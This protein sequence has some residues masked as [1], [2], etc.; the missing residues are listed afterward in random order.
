[1]P[2]KLIVTAKETTSSDALGCGERAARPEAS[3]CLRASSVLAIEDRVDEPKCDV[4]HVG[5]LSPTV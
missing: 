3:Q 2:T 5:T 1:M 4:P